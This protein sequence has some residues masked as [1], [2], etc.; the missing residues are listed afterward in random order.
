M[1]GDGDGIIDAIAN[2]FANKFE[3]DECY[4]VSVGLCRVVNMVVN[5]DEIVR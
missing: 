2:K 5:G 1:S 4:V 3:C